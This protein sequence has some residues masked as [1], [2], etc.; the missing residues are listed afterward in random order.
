MKFITFSAQQ[1]ILQ[2][3]SDRGRGGVRMLISCMYQIEMTGLIESVVYITT[4]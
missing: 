2:Y 1:N 4:K 3:A